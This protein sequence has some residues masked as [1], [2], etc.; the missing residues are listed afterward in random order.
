[1]IENFMF[2]K[3]IYPIMDRLVWTELGSID[4]DFHKHILDDILCRLGIFYEIADEVVETDI[5]LLEKDLK[6]YRIPFLQQFYELSFVHILLNVPH[7]GQ[8]KFNIEHIIYLNYPMETQ[9]CSQKHM[10]AS[11][12]TKKI[13]IGCYLMPY[14][15]K[16]LRRGF[17]IDSAQMVYP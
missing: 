10:T 15:F 16:I 2:G 7:T 14:F 13:C 1:M 11:V 5:I 8:A 4:P 17:W 12:N 6:T 3:N 9:K